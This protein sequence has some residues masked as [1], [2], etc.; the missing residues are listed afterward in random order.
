MSWPFRA[1]P[2]RNQ[3]AGPTAPSDSLIAREENII[4]YIA[5]LPSLDLLRKSVRSFDGGR[6]TERLMPTGDI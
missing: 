5:L 2:I 3:V 4:D 1:E 6:E